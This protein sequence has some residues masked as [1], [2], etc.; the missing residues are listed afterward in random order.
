MT[1]RG[2]ERLLDEDREELQAVRGGDA[3]R[4][5]ARDENARSR[6]ESARLSTNGD[7]SAPREDIEHVVTLVVPTLVA[8]IVEAQQAL[9]KLGTAD[10][11]RL[12]P[13]RLLDLDAV[14]HRASLYR[15]FPF[16]S[17]VARSRVASQFPRRGAN[18]GRRCASKSENVPRRRA[19]MLKRVS[20]IVATAG[21]IVAV[22]AATLGGTA[23][24]SAAKISPN[25]KT[26]GIGFASVLSG[27]NA[28]LGNDQ[29][30]WTRVF[31]LYW[32]SGKPIPGVPKKFHRTKIKVVEIGDSQLNPQV[33]ATVGGQMVSNK[34]VLAMLGFVGSN[35]TL[36]GGPVL[37]RAGLS[38]VSSSATRDDLAKKLKLFHR[39]VP[40]NL[41]QATLATSYLLSHHVIK[42]GQQAMVVDDAEAYG[43]NQADDMEKLLKAAHLKVDRESVP[44]STANS[45]ADFTAVA[46]KAV[47]IGAKVVLAP[48]QTA[49]DS[50]LFTQ[51]LKSAGYHGVF[52]AADG[53]FNPKQF[54]FP[55]AYVS[56]FGADVTKVK[57]ARPYLKT[58]T[59]RYGQTIGFG[60][61]AFTAAEM[62][63][64]AISNSCKDGTTSRSQVTKALHK[65]RLSNSLLGLPVAFNF[66]GDLY[67]GP[68]KGVTYFKI[69][70]NGSYKQVA[71]S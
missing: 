40:N 23:S 15:G 41:A 63:A 46:N 55:G 33:A 61:T 2:R 56:Y 57:V 53:S 37:D 17:R 22:V 45:N 10:E 8:R 64:M 28:A 32:N 20:V 14:P 54:N 52:T 6:F 26:G 62:V 13:V 4:R 29:L 31:L 21:V 51:Q 30:H 12:R 65:V 59:K 48:T 68:K 58:F 19:W 5:S 11:R 25:C 35:E 18:L 39:V 27:P 47:A 42:A 16:L 36:G 60:P 66:K 9:P 38:Y 70:A 24:A 34:K 49:S 67:K 69:Q 1:G 3:P 7:R 50:E 43:Q 44:E 71:S